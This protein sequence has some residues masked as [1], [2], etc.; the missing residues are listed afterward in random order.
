MPI[1]RKKACSQCRIAKTRCNLARTCSRCVQRGFQC[2]YEEAY[3]RQMSYSSQPQPH[4]DFPAVPLVQHP[5]LMQIEAPAPDNGLPDCAQDIELTGTNYQEN[6]AE[7][8]PVDTS[9]TGTPLWGALDDFFSVPSS[10]FSSSLNV[11]EEVFQQSPG[12]GMLDQP[13]WASPDSHTLS[14][15][16][17]S[18]TEEQD[19]F[20]VANRNEYVV[21]AGKGRFATYAKRFHDVHSPKDPIAMQKFLTSQMI[22]SQIDTYPEM[23][24]QGQLPPFIYPTCFLQ[25]QSIKTCVTNGTHQCLPESL[26]ICANL[27]HLFYKATPQSHSFVW[28]SIN[29]EQKR[30]KS[31]VSVP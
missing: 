20:G 30:L 24:I 8:K 19:M 18:N 16:R 22:W 6:L 26:A 5:D 12:S 17:Q 15:I 31:D 11:M 23:M 3:S 21:E 2:Y 1:S 28:R 4:G 7:G 14:L 9:T 25:D 13:N 29:A 10:S 27:L